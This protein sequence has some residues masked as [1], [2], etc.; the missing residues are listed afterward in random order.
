[1][2]L[3]ISVWTHIFALFSFARNE[4]LNP[5]VEF[6]FLGLQ[7]SNDNLGRKNARI[8]VNECSTDALNLILSKD[9]SEKFLVTTYYCYVKDLENAVNRC[10]R[11]CKLSRSIGRCKGIEERLE[12]NRQVYEGHKDDQVKWS[13]YLLYCLDC[14]V[15]TEYKL[16]QSKFNGKIIESKG[17]GGHEDSAYTLTNLFKSY[18]TTELSNTEILYIKNSDLYVQLKKKLCKNKSRALCK[19][20]KQTLETLLNKKG[21]LQDALA[22]QTDYQ[23]RCYAFLSR[24]YNG[25]PSSGEPIENISDKCRDTARLETEIMGL[26]GGTTNQVYSENELDETFELSVL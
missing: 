17:G 10:R 15:L 5:S 19:C 6:S 22:R 25:L 1:M 13:S 4:I 8:S 23:K 3:L 21:S 24:G 20:A 26:T 11:K 14:R 9:Q 2:K 12:K 7:A 18:I 16:I